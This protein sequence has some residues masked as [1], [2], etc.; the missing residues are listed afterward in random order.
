MNLT[1]PWEM[2][3]IILLEK[4]IICQEYKKLEKSRTGYCRKRNQ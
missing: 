1:L 4:Q 3:M 2:P